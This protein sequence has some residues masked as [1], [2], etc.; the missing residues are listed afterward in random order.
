MDVDIGLPGMANTVMR[1][2]QNT[3][4]AFRWRTDLHMLDRPTF[5]ALKLYR[6][7]PPVFH[8]DIAFESSAL[9]TIALFVLTIRSRRRKRNGFD[10]TTVNQEAK[11]G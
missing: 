8:L 6:L 4:I 5:G 10:V 2:D 9:V 11:G 7:L 1:L 3:P